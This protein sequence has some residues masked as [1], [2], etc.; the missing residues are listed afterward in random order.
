MYMPHV[1]LQL[2]P[3]ILLSSIADYYYLSNIKRLTIILA[4][5]FTSMLI[6]IEA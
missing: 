2:L 5:L 3:I 6:Y 1:A 4:S